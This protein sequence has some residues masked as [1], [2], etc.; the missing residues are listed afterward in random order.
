M[1][2]KDNDLAERLLTSKFG[3]A[4]KLRR[5]MIE[6]AE[7][8]SF[9]Q[10]ELIQKAGERDPYLYLI[11]DGLCRR[12]YVNDHKEEITTDFYGESEFMVGESMFAKYAKANYE[13]L[14]DMKVLRFDAQKVKPAIL[15]D[16]TTA[17]SYIRKLEEAVNHN[18]DREDEFAHKPVADRYADYKK[19]H[20][21]LID[22]IPTKVLASYLGTTTAGLSRV[23]GH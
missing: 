23:K 4:A 5:L 15:A 22:R 8:A 12:Y 2:T 21:D 20:P 10:G 19:A 6:V 16:L 13:A 18:I 3:P 1:G 17:R 11:A 7:T 9:K 14:E